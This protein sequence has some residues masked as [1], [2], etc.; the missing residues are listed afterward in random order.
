MY[1]CANVLISD[2][3]NQI[4]PPLFTKSVKVIVMRTVTKITETLDLR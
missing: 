2:N 1:H 3:L 4:I